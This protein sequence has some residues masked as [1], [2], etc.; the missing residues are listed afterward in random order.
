M[1]D[2]SHHMFNW[3]VLNPCVQFPDQLQHEPENATAEQTEKPL[4]EPLPEA[5]QEVEVWFNRQC[6]SFSCVLSTGFIVDLYHWIKV[7]FF[8]SGDRAVH[9]SA[10]HTYWGGVKWDRYKWASAKPH[11]SGCP[12]AIRTHSN[13]RTGA[14]ERTRRHQARVLCISVGKRETP[15]IQRKTSGKQ[16]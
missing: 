13:T 7:S 14:L 3:D 16:L 4:S 10:C 5:Y 12:S 2:N 11:P 8:E 6:Y 1:D 9:R 15:Q